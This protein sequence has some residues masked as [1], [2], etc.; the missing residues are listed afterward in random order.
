M[1]MKQEDVIDWKRVVHLF[2]IG[3]AASL[4]AFAGDMLLG[5]SVCDPEA[6]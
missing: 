1:Q 3:I 4:T 2:K 5:W 6:V